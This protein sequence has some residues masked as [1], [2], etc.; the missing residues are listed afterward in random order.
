LKLLLHRIPAIVF[1]VVALGIAAVGGA[2]AAN[3]GGAAIRVCVHHKGGAL[4]KAKKCAKHDS[5]LRWNVQGVQ[6]P[7]G[8]Q[9]LPGAQSAPGANGTAVAFAHVFSNGTLDTTNSKNVDAAFHAGVGSV[10]LRLTVPVKAASVAIDAGNSLGNGG[11]ASVT[12][13]GE[14][15]NNVI[16]GLCTPLAGANALVEPY[17]VSGVGA[18]R[19]FWISLN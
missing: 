13:S 9:G 16:G 14:D 10:C 2:Y 5:A 15:P 11:F 19:A 3:G 8:P 18:D 6:G 12:L 4:Y 7:A 17:G 1:G